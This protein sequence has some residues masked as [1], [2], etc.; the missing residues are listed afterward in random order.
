[1]ARMA[2]AKQ[3]RFER[4]ITNFD[5]QRVRIRSVAG[6]DSTITHYTEVQRAVSLAYNDLVAHGKPVSSGYE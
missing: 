2:S 3:L 5:E 1:M 6:V 4:K